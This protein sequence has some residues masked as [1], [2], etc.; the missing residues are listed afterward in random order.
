MTQI[1]SRAQK[2]IWFDEIVNLLTSNWW[3]A[4]GESR[5]FGWNWIKFLHFLAHTLTWTCHA[6]TEAKLVLGGG[7]WYICKFNDIFDHIFSNL[8]VIFFS[9]FHH[10]HHRHHNDHP[11][12]HD[13]HNFKVALTKIATLHRRLW[14]SIT[15]RRL[16]GGSA[17][18][19]HFA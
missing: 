7:Q 18:T 12:G 6:I 3:E 8:F 2:L 17:Q 1:W 14:E 9:S 4:S 11:R 5:E 19:H 10:H 13:H 16:T 15:L